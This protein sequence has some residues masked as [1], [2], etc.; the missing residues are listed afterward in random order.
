MFLTCVF[1]GVRSGVCECVHR[2]R[3]LTLL[4]LP[5]FGKERIVKTCCLFVVLAGALMV[6]GGCGRRMSNVVVEPVVFEHADEVVKGVGDS[7][8][9]WALADRRVF[10]VMAFLNATG[11]DQE[12]ANRPMHPVRVKVR[13]MMA[14][15]LAEH[16]EKLER[17]RKYHAE[18]RIG[19]WQYVNFALSLS[20]DYPFRRIRAGKELT[21]SWTDWML[22]DFAEVV[23]DF[24]VRGRLE[25]IWAACRDDYARELASCDPEKTARGIRS[26]WVYLR[27]ERKDDYIIVRVPNPLERHS[28]A[29]GHRFERYF[30]SVEGPLSGGYIH[31]YLHTIVNDLVDANYKAQE[32][33]LKEYFEAGK[34]AE[35]SASYQEVA[36]WVTECMIHAID[37]RIAVQRQTDP[38]GVERIE[39]RVDALTE[40]GYH[41]LRPF[42]ALLAE[43]ENSEMAFDQYLPIMLEKLPEYSQQAVTVDG[44]G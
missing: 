39:A 20:S 29:S 38:S 36:G 6:A 15:N 2:T 40:G 33:K 25:E 21:Y 13:E 7:E 10:A 32:G 31:E 22:A 14:E 18:R 1:E 44:N 28:T 42:Y 8:G 3:F 17:W 12:V 5:F 24:W 43:F 37:Y 27:M 16:G 9:Y 4:I 34:D 26:V 41:V 35:I 30:Y 19:A 23:N 11:Y